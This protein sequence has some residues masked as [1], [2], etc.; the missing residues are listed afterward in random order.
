MIHPARTMPFEDLRG[1]L[2]YEYDNERVTRQVDGSLEQYTYSQSCVYDRAWNSINEMARGLILDT[3]AKQVAATP[4]PKFF[5]HGERPDIPALPFEVF[6]KLDGSL[7]IIFWHEGRWRTATK[8]S[9]NSDQAK[10]AE[11][12]WHGRGIPGI[13]YLCE[14]VGPQNKIVIPY[15]KEELVLLGAYEQDGEEYDYLDLCMFADLTGMRLA[16]RYSYPNFAALL[17]TAATLP[18]TQEGFVIRFS[19]GYRLKVKGDEY[20]R[21][22]RLVSRVTPLAIWEAMVAG[23][24]LEAVRREL[25][26][27]FWP[28]F[29]TITHNLRT[30]TADLMSTASEEAHTRQHMTDKEVGLALHTIPEG[31]RSL[32]FPLRKQGAARARQLVLRQVRPTGNVL[33]GYRPSGAM[34]RM[35]E[36]A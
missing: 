2:L 23:D 34:N 26:E 29:D 10:A 5:N 16:A 17:A 11:R 36:A 15:D 25:P 21:I 12:L 3:A 31:V 27:E 20:C 18:A 28:D 30:R 1:L 24:D 6:E 14:Y 8:G 22:H 7:I 9:F 4:F 33:D 35:A 32:V 19:N 13:T